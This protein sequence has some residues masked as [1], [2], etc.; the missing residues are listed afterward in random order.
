MTSLRY[1]ALALVLIGCV[2][3]TQAQSTPD[4]LNLTYTTV[5]VPAAG[6][7]AVASINTVGDMVGWYAQADNTPTSGFLLSGGNFTLFNYPGADQ[8]FATGINDSGKIVG[9]A[10]FHGNTEAVSFSYDGTTFTTIRAP[11]KTYTIVNGVNNG[12]DIVGGDGFT[13]GNHGFEMIGARFKNV[14][15]PGSYTLVYATG[16]NNLGKIV[17]WT[18][19]ATT[20]GFAYKAGTFQTLNFPGSNMTEVWGINDA[21]VAVGWYGTAASFSGFAL[22]KGKYAPLNFPGALATFAVGIN[23]SGQI[24]GQYEA[25]D[26]TYHGFMASP[27][28]AQWGT[29]ADQ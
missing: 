5:D 25:V 15:P 4:T 26:M 13:G 11:G 6:L 10:Y 18:F 24:V 2:S 3:F 27:A 9:Y 22:M 19:G 12:G 1:V 14:T 21:G 8:T 23:A 29:I 17:G 20:S 7:T 28:T 16:V